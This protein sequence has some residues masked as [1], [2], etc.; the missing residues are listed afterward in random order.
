MRLSLMCATSAFT[1]FLLSACGGSG[2]SGSTTV[3]TPSGDVM[4]AQSFDMTLTASAARE[5]DPNTPVTVTFTV[6]IPERAQGEARPLIIHSHGFGGSRIGTEEADADPTEPA[7]IDSTTSVFSRIDDQVRLLWDAGYIVV[8][9]DERGF[10]RGGDDGDNG[11]T[12]A[13]QIMDPDFEIR[14]AIDVLDWADANIDNIARDADGDM[15]A[16]AIGGSYGG[17]YQLLLAALDPRLDAI[18]PT[19]TWYDLLQS[20][21]PNDVI[22]K[23]Y[24]TGLCALIASDGAEAGRRNQNACNQASDLGAPTARYREDIP[25]DM[26]MAG[27]RD[28]LLNAFF[29]HGLVEFERMQTA[30]GFTLRPVDAL[31]IQGNRDILFNLTQAREN[32]RYLS[33]AG[34]DVRLLSME[35]GH[36]IRQT[37]MN[38]GSQGPLGNSACG[39]LDALAATR[40]WFDL[41]LRD[42]AS[43][44]T[45]LPPEVCV[46]LNDTTGVLLNELPFAAAND[47]RFND[48]TVTIPVTGVTAMASNVNSPAD[49]IFVAGPTIISDG[50]VLAGVPVASVT[51]TDADALAAQNNG[52]TAFIGTAINRGGEII[53][54][55]DQAQPIRASDARTGDTPQ[56]IPLIGVGE[57]L[58]TG[59]VVGVLIYGNF[60]QYETGTGSL[61]TNFGVNNRFNIAGSV[62]LPVVTAPVQSRVAAA[63]G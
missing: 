30:G 50:Q 4:P 55:D 54:V 34:G 58:Q 48:F 44:A 7:A 28:E 14:D 33:G 39:S 43:A 25:A 23:A 63:G 10:G 38:P 53:L 60:D 37:R 59:D 16:G 29:T 1:L 2:G 22:K 49:G 61:P 15:L 9:F 26:P 57:Q 35:N 41:K 45:A 6:F 17:G 20:L 8:S 47:T 52:S 62:R 46:S 31:L 24:S 18:V 27:N 40:A 12:G 32:Y 3:S 56:P 11:N 42:V 19:A 13:I 36:S 5:D 51:I 21:L